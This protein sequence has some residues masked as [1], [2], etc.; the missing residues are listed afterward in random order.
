[1]STPLRISE[2]NCCGP[3]CC[4]GDEKHA[5][6]TEV[7]AVVREKYGSTARAGLSSD[8][9]GVRA[10]AEAFG[11]SSSELS[12]IPAEANMGLSCGNPTAFASLKLGETVV[13][14]GCGGGLD[15]FLAAQKV[16]PTGKGIGIDM[17]A[18]MIALARKNAQPG[19]DGQPVA[20]VE[21]HEAMID[22]LPLP[23]GSVDVIISNCV[24]NL[25]PDK[26]AVFREMFRVLKPGG[27]VAVSDIAIKKP[28][29]AELER[30]V[31]AYVGCIAGAIPIAEYRAGLTEAGFDAVDVIDSGTDLNAYANVQGQSGC[32]SPAMTTPA[33]TSPATPPPS[34][35]PSSSSNRG[36]TIAPAPASACCAP[37]GD[38]VVHAGLGG[39]LQR[40]DV[41][42]YAASVK[43]YAVKGR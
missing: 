27:R 25:A 5:A 31:M 17:T 16:G 10:V 24:I 34:S 8:Q 11:Y 37:T 28:L 19:P 22:A 9:A 4:G 38:A 18:D 40:Y 32:C 41:N 7:T 12:S 39:L 20:N 14:L 26:R 2:E 30:D 23:D 42:E 35:S 15:V 43:V 1:M 13:D 6:E 33:T 36:L 29:P 21:F 3:S